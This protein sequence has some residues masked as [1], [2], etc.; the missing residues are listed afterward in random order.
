MQCMII[1]VKQNR[2]VQLTHAQNTQNENEA[3][4]LTLIV[5]EQYSTFNKKIVF[6]TPDGIFWDIMVNNEY[7]LTTA[8]TKYKKVDFYIWLTKGDVDFRSKTRPLRFYTNEEVEELTP[9]EISGVN[10]VI[11]LL[12]EEI[13]KVNAL[14]LEID[15]KL[16]DVN[17][18]IT[19]T[20]NLNIDANKVDKTTTVTLTKKDA[21]TKT[22]RIADGISL[23]FRWQGTY[24]GI[25]TEDEQ[26]YTYVNLQGIQRSDRS[27]R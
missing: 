22:V 27:T 26:E 23:Q 15:G 9:E 2:E 19:Q 16:A 11:N 20:N 6:I 10:T 13:A 25:K 3:E 14:E 4:K 24:L 8:I 7:Y 17:T 12:E 1:D 21:T 18:A 5:P